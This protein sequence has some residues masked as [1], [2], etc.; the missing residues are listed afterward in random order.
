MRCSILVLLAVLVPSLAFAQG[1]VGGWDPE[2]LEKAGKADEALANY[3]T[4]VKTA[5][6]VSDVRLEIFKA[7]LDRFEKELNKS[8]VE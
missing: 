4:A 5:K 7:N 6:R 2:A 1:K 3:T 8:S